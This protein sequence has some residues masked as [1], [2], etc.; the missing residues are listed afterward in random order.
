MASERTAIRAQASFEQSGPHTI[1]SL[2]LRPLLAV[3]LIL[4]TT[5]SMAHRRRTSSLGTSS[6]AVEQLVAGTTP[7]DEESPLRSAGDL[8]APSIEPMPPAAPSTSTVAT[9][10]AKPLPPVN[11]ATRRNNTSSNVADTIRSLEW[12]AIDAACEG[13]SRA[14][15]QKAEVCRRSHCS[16]QGC[17]W[18][19][20]GA[21]KRPIDMERF[22]ADVAR[23]GTRQRNRKAA[24]CT[25]SQLSRARQVSWAPL[26][27]RSALY[28]RPRPAVSSMNVSWPAM[29]I[30]LKHDACQ[31]PRVDDA[32]EHL[33]QLHAIAEVRGAP[34]G[35]HPVIMLRG[36]SI[37]RG[38]SSAWVNI[39]R[40]QPSALDR[41]VHQDI[42]YLVTSTGDFWCQGPHCWTSFATGKSQ[43]SFHAAADDRRDQGIV[44]FEL[45][46]VIATHM[47]QTVDGYRRVL[48]SP[49]YDVRRALLYIGGSIFHSV[50]PE[51]SPGQRSVW[52]VDRALNQHDDNVDGDERPANADGTNTTALGTTTTPPRRR[53]S[54]G[55]DR[56]RTIVWRTFHMFEGVPTNPPPPAWPC[57]KM[58]QAMLAE[59]AALNPNV[60]RSLVV[61]VTDFYDYNSSDYNMWGGPT[62][63]HTGCIVRDLTSVSGIVMSRHHHLCW[64][65]HDMALI[66]MSVAAAMAP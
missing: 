54:D 45:R 65:V 43:H 40:Q 46:H 56:Y 58:Q 11:A 50:V 55:S 63:F 16:A 66:Q 21:W 38:T 29:N 52:A 13:Y 64:N 5:C 39:F 26:P 23:E 18:F 51:P 60:A 35:Q 17:H 37:Q 36:D 59:V 27:A 42:G 44:L 24:L 62:D 28:G 8:P 20:S 4:T 6:M 61:N 48:Q 49:E 31:L 10:T 34:P 30:S 1:G 47:F 22:R 32:Y 12:L 53:P 3:V 41:Y 19:A 57:L 14:R 7:L 2:T 9:D 25:F 15:Q 33:V